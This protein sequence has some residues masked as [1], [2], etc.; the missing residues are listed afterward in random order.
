MNSIIVMVILI[1]V[2]VFVVDYAILV[3]IADTD[4]KRNETDNSQ[5][6]HDQ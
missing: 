2:I 5:E 4:S 3:L 6:R 1:P